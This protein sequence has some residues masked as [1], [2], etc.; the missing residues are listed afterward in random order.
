MIQVLCFMGPPGSGKGYNSTKIYD[1]YKNFIDL[2]RFSVGDHLR[3][4]N[5]A[6]SKGNL[7]DIEEVVSIIDSFL[8]KKRSF[9]IIDG[10]PRSV[11]QAKVLVDRFKS[12]VIAN[13]SLV[14]LVVSDESVLISRLL[15]RKN[16][17]ECGFSFSKKD[18][19][20]CPCCSGSCYTR[21][22]DLAHEAI[23]KRIE[24]HNLSYILI[25]DYLKQNNFNIL[26]F[27]VSAEKE[28]VYTEIV[29]KVSKFFEK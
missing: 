3:K 17:S 28:F 16:C 26:E 7:S 24:I 8:D 4:K 21:E 10:Y 6:D 2:E 18:G 14:S 12:G 9:Y 1:E 11:E 29:K 25:K 20:V 23:K 22:D 27:D 15:D 19:S 13:L 5:K